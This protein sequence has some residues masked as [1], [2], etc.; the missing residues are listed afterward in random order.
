MTG[1]LASMAIG[2]LALFT[3]GGAGGIAR[4]Q[5]CNIKKDIFWDTKDG[6]P[7]FSQG[8]GIFR[9]KDTKTNKEQGGNPEWKTI[10]LESVRVA[11]NK[12]EIGFL[13]DGK[14]GAF[15]RVDDVSLVKAK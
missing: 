15:C 14:A 9:F 7:I 4:A 11:G 12:V 2:C 10:R 1:K 13:A 5:P 8:G 6:L 3:L